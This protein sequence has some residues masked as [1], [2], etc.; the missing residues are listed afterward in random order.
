MTA[1]HVEAPRRDQPGASRTAQTHKENYHTFLPMECERATPYP[2]AVP[3]P[4]TSAATSP[5][6]R[7]FLLL[8]DVGQTS[9]EPTPNPSNRSICNKVFTAASAAYLLLS[10]MKERHV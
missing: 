3:L 7:T 8:L 5:L 10:T 6:D 4:P 2:L 1:A 9:A